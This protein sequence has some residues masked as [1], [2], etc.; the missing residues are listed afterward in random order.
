[1]G[2]F[3]ILMRDHSSALRAMHDNVNAMK[4]VISGL[5]RWEAKVVA[6]Y[7]ML[8]EWDQCYIVDAPNNFLAYRATLAQEWSVT[9]DTVILPAVDMPL[10]ERLISQEIRTAGPHRWQVHWWARWVRFALY[11]YNYGRYARRFFTDHQTHGKENLAEL[12][13]PC[14][15]VC[16]HAS[17]YDQYCLM[18]ALPWKLRTNLYIGAAADRW[19]L[20]GRKEITMQPWYVSLALGTYPIQ[21]GGGSRTLDYPKWLLSQGAN[22]M[23]FPEGTRAR[24]KKLSRFK[25]GVSILAKEA[26]VPVL[27]VYLEGLQKIRPPGQR[28]STPGP[29]AAHILPPLNFAEDTTV[30]EASD[31]IYAAMLA[32][33]QALGGE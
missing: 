3:V 33:H 8:G 17:H 5:E 23:L 15:V 1:M 27:P 7:R 4:G 13:T 6:S 11:D 14:I 9:K 22:L 19:F 20:R 26:G 2:Q 28:E 31:Q 10:F 16:N 32:K 12:N 30:P 25:H 21:R 24:G 18:Q 29:V